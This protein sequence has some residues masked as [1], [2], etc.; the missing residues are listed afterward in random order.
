MVDG[1]A[2]WFGAAGFEVLEIIDDG[3]E[4]VIEVETTQRLVGCSRRGTRAIPR[5]PVV[6]LRVR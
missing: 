5:P 2:L 6:T 4:W 1:S 3:T